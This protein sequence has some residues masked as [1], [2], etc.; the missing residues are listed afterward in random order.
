MSIDPSFDPESVHCPSEQQYGG[1]SEPRQGQSASCPTVPSELDSA[2]RE[3]FVGPG[4]SHHQGKLALR[5]NNKTLKNVNLDNVAPSL[6]APLSTSEE[7]PLFTPVAASVQWV[8]LRK[9]AGST[10][11]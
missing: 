5:S 6:G 2:V 8:Y 10:R 7:I 9:S 11:S 4:D 3:G 1:S